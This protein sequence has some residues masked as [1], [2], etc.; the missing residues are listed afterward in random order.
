MRQRSFRLP[1]KLWQ[2]RFRARIELPGRLFGGQSA[3][4]WGKFNVSTVFGLPIVVDSTGVSPPVSGFERFYE[5]FSGHRP[6]A[7]RASTLAWGSKLLGGF[8]GYVVDLVG[9]DGL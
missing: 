1:A 8:W 2:T 9:V 5:R 6:L 4:C 7:S 3:L